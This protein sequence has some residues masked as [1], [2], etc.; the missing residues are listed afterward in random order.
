RFYSSV[1]ACEH[2]GNCCLYFSRLA[3]A[4]AADYILQQAVETPTGP[5]D[6]VLGRYGE[7]IWQNGT[8]GMYQTI[9]SLAQHVGR[10]SGGTSAHYCFSPTYE[11]EWPICSWPASVERKGAAT[12]EGAPHKIILI[13]PSRGRP[14][15]GAEAWESAYCRRKCKNTEVFIA[16]DQN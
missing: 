10:N 9:S 6:L 12:S 3:V 16:V 8:G 5:A 14:C 11:R 1:N 2:Y 13:I 7:S 15:D 4:D